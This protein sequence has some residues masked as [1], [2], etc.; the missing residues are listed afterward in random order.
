MTVSDFEAFYRGTAPRLMRLAYG[1][2]GGLAEAQDFTQ[3]AYARAWQRWPTLQRYDN[4]E[5]WLRL[6]VTRLATDWWRRLRVRRAAQPPEPDVVPPPD[7]ELMSLV[8]ALRT[9][10]VDQRRALALHYLLDQSVADIAAEM[11]VSVNTVKSWL[12]RGR[13]SLAAALGDRSHVN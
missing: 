10:P 8:A 11:S 13:A 3:E 7:E 9:L 1:L 5:A 2:T 6:V 12:A 4:P